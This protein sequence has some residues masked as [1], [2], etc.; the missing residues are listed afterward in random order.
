MPGIR[1][2]GSVWVVIA[3]CSCVGLLILGQG[4]WTRSRRLDQPTPIRPDDTVWI[5]SGRKGV[6]WHGVDMSNDSVS[7]IP[8]TQSLRCDECR[9]RISRAE[10]DSIVVHSRG[11]TQYLAGAAVLFA[12][13]KWYVFNPNVR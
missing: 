6:R 11:V 2:K 5:W 10:V 8:Y 12:F 4:C 13:F 1:R 7:G 3:R 9:Q